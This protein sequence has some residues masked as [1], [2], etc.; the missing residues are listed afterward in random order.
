MNCIVCDAKINLLDS[1][2]LKEE[3]VI[4]NKKEYKQ[5]DDKENTEYTYVED[6][7]SFSWV[8]GSVSMFRVGYGSKFDGCEI[9]IA[10]CD[11][12]ID[13]SIHSGK[14]ALIKNYHDLDGDMVRRLR[15]TWRRNKNLNGLI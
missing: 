14:S 12:C 7:S 4:F 10:V 6:A 1:N 2:S 8:E 11:N 13:K 15:K 3:D 9:V 5:K